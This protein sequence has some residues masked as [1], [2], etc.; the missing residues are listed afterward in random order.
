LGWWCGKAREQLKEIT[1][2][3]DVVAP[4]PMRVVQCRGQGLALGRS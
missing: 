1:G 4:A 3:I 2:G